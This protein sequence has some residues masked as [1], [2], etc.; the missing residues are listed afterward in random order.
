MRRFLALL[1]L[2]SSLSALLASL[3]PMVEV[4][5][6]LGGVVLAGVG[7]IGALVNLLMELFKHCFSDASMFSLIGCIDVANGIRLCDEC[8]QRN[9]KCSIAGYVMQ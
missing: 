9:G 3:Q 6:S 1:S 5:S 8:R 2:V 7:I 4:N